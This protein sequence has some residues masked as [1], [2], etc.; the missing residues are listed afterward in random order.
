YWNIA[1]KSIF[2]L[3]VN[4]VRV[5]INLSRYLCINTIKNPVLCILGLTPVN[6]TGQKFTSIKGKLLIIPW[7][8]LVSTDKGVS[9]LLSATAYRYHPKAAATFARSRVGRSG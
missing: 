2:S 8:P 7:S 1:R 9:T 4:T 6:R 3:R 5:Q